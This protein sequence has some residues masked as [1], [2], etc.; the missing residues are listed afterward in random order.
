MFHILNT[1]VLEALWVYSIP[2]IVLEFV[3]VAKSVHGGLTE[4][5]RKFLLRYIWLKNFDVTN[6]QDLC[7]N[8]FCMKYGTVRKFFTFKIFA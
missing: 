6:F 8:F 3:L 2:K 5:S 1:I 7:E 4:V